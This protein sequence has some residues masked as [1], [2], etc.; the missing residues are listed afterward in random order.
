MVTVVWKCQT[1]DTDKML[2]WALLLLIRASEG[3]KNATVCSGQEI[4]SS[5]GV[6]TSSGYPKHIVHPTLTWCSIALPDE[7]V[8]TV[9]VISTSVHNAQVSCQ[10]CNFL[11][12]KGNG[13]NA[14]RICDDKKYNPFLV[15]GRV[16]ITFQYNFLAPSGAMFALHYAVSTN[17]G[18]DNFSCMTTSGCFT[19]SQI[20]DG[21]FQCADHSD[22]IN[23]AFCGKNLAPCNNT[24][25]KCFEVLGEH[26]D[27]R[28]QCPRANDEINCF[29]GCSEGVR[30]ANGR[31]CF[32][33][34][35]VCDGRANCMDASD[36]VNCTQNFCELHPKERKFFCGN[37]KCIAYSLVS[38]GVDDC[39]DGSDEKENA[40]K[41]VV[42][43]LVVGSCLFGLFVTILCCWCNG[44]RDIDHLIA[45]M[46]EFPLPPFQGTLAY[47]L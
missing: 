32:L 24:G 4:S 28:F 16:N 33:P 43:I 26:C 19:P 2:F 1:F 34:E 27:G 3:L 44:R 9:R 12:I 46:P 11:E 6:I 21:S 18:R 40:H 15:K 37:D 8:T 31:G 5:R 22:E 47:N 36:E 35:Q 41:T 23:C 42:A 29:E 20:C 14:R 30:C 45:N 39:G 17:C 25:V 7:A 38:N 13:K 10:C